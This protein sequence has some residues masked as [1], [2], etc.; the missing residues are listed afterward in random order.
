MTV[1]LDFARMTRRLEQALLAAGERVVRVAPHRAGASRRG[2]RQPGKSD[3]IDSL[4]IARAVVKDGV[5][6]FPAPFMR[7][8]YDAGASAYVLKE[9]VGAIWAAAGR[10]ARELPPGRR[11]RA[12]R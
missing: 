7:Q 9:L 10:A 8:A 11:P 12:D 2:E 5:E 3:E 1:T 4:A 6:Q